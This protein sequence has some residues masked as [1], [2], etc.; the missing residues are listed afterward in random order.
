MAQYP[1]LS[2]IGIV[3]SIYSILYYNIYIFKIY[4]FWG[5]N[6]Y[7]FENIYILTQ[8]IYFFP[9][10]IYI[11]ENIYIFSP[12]YIFF[13]NIYILAIY[14]IFSKY[15]YFPKY[16]YFGQKWWKKFFKLIAGKIKIDEIFITFST[17]RYLI[18]NL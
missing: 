8:K 10:N 4:I 6:I 18:N 16:I 1:V 11:L 13:G 14:S 2:T 5:E 3:N 15:I 7:S 17:F 9:E 12:K